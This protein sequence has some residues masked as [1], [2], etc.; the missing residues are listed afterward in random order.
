M[1][2][3]LRSSYPVVAEPTRPSSSPNSLFSVWYASGTMASG[4]GLLA[5]LVFAY[6]TATAGQRLLRFGEEPGKV[7]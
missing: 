2:M 6:L 1:A 4:A 7:S 5:L 3:F